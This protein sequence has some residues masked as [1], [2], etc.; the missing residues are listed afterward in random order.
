ML[1]SPVFLELQQQWSLGYLEVQ[2]VQL[3]PGHQED[4]EGRGDPGEKQTKLS[5]S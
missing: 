1:D 3:V 4:L 2:G 5:L